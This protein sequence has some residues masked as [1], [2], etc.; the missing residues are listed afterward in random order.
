M[1][2]ERLKRAGSG[3][4]RVTL[5]RTGIRT[6]AVDP[7]LE[8]I[9]KSPPNAGAGGAFGARASLLDVGWMRDALSSDTVTTRVPSIE[10]RGP[11]SSSRL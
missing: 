11:A 6:I 10:S 2:H 8:Q 5:G 9:G 1:L 4:T 7:L 3:P